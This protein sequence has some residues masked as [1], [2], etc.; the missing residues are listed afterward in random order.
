MT[1]EKRT[2]YCDKCWWYVEADH[3]RMIG[4]CWNGG[5]PVTSVTAE[6]VCKY[7]TEEDPRK[8]SKY[9]YN[10]NQRDGKA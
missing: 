8:D 7:F 4:H 1:E 6:F 2:K 9:E 5:V 10:K 3:R